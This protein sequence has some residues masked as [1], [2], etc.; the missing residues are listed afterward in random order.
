[1]RLP[2]MVMVIGLTAVATMMP[3]VDG[4]MVGGV[5]PPKSGS[6]SRSLVPKTL[7][8]GQALPGHNGN[9]NSGK[10]V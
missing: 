10:P 4:S 1:M 3:V 7:P 2:T 8:D 6:P 9:V 5:L